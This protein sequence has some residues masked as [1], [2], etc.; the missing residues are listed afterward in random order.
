MARST[1]NAIIALVIGLVE[2]PMHRK[3]G[4]SNYCARI[5]LDAVGSQFGELYSIL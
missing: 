2:N 3:V 5:T 1:V 4:A